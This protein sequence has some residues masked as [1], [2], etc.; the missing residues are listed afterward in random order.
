LHASHTYAE[1][2]LVD[3]IAGVVKLGEEPIDHLVGIMLG[4]QFLHQLGDLNTS[5]RKEAW[6]N[7]DRTHL[8]WADT[9]VGD[10]PL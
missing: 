1:E 7:M 5:A 9:A 3:G 4:R 2:P 8:V 10:E 6:S